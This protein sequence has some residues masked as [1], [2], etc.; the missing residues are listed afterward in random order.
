MLST[1]KKRLFQISPVPP[2]D[3]PQ[4]SFGFVV[5]GQGIAISPGNYTDV[6]VP[7]DCTITNFYIHSINATTGIDLAGNCVIDIVRSGSSIIGAGNKPTLVS[8]ASAAENVLGWTSISVVT[9]DR[10]SL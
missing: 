7:Y 2:K 8:S 9:G 4:G 3:H 5:D 6:I 10:L 1:I